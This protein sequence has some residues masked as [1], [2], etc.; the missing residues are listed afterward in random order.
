VPEPTDADP[1]HPPASRGPL[2]AWTI[3]RTW[4]LGPDEPAPAVVDGGFSDDLQL[5]LYLACEGH[6][7]DLGRIDEWD[8][9]LLAFR[10]RLEDAFVAELRHR[11]GRDVRR[12][13]RRRI[14]L[15]EAIPA[16]IEA[17]TG[18]SLSRYMEAHGTLAQMRDFVLHRSAYQL[19]EGDAHTLGIARLRGRAKQ[20][21]VAIQA[22][23]YGADEPGRVMHSEL[24]AQTMRGLGLDDR[25]NA[26]LDRLPASAL[27]VSNLI[28]LLGLN[29]RWRGALVGHLAVFEMTSVVP[30]GRYGRA[31]ERLGAAEGTRRFYDVHVLA[32]AEHER[33]ALDMAC[34]LAADEPELIDDIL[35]GAY[36][37][38]AVEAEFA[39][40]LLRSWGALALAA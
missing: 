32:D 6:F 4:R 18:P 31:L 17:D 12:A 15:R 34:A 39:E 30:M 33:M 10:R 9:P 14:D 16:L 37:V 13:V 7:S 20:A 29:R 35:F 8:P 27:M 2:S 21:L 38:L 26:Y 23:E 22:G 40:T 5:S 25:P 11:V 36:A 24:F 3:N 19:K 28:S 1:S